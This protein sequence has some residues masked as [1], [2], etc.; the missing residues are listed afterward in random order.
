[1]ADPCLINT[2]AIPGCTLVNGQPSNIAIVKDVDGTP[3]DGTEVVARYL[4]SLGTVD[5]PLNRITLKSKTT[6]LPVALPPYRFGFPEVQPL[7]GAQP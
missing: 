7:L 6:G 2:I 5:T 3:L 4:E 1:V